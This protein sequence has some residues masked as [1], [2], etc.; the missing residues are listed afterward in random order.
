MEF[1]KKRQN[2]FAILA[3]VIVVFTLL[4][5]HLSLNRQVAKLG[6]MFTDGIYIEKDKYTQPG[7]QTHLDA[8]ISASL[9]L[10]TVA[11]N[12]EAVSAET[13]SLL[14]ARHELLDA[15]TVSQKYE[16]NQKLEVAYT[17]LAAG[18]E[19]Q[20]LSDTDADNAATYI[21]NLSGA[22]GAIEKSLYNARVAE[23]ETGVLAVFP[24]SA[25]R[26]FVFAESPEY[27]GA[28]A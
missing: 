25:L 8:R 2:A 17:A 27:F 26:G 19:A 11:S 20:D 16:A 7:I 14:E 21:S 18:L 12:Y 5:V 22:Q 10:L 15:E 28:E 6:S 1:I 4:G 24:V 9:G 13:E 3:A 23:Y